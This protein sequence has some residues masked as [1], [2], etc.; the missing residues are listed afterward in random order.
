MLPEGRIGSDVCYFTSTFVDASISV[1]W[2]NLKWNSIQFAIIF[3]FGDFC[4]LI[5]YNVNMKSS[6]QHGVFRSLCKC[7][8]CGCEGHSSDLK[9]VTSYPGTFTSILFDVFHVSEVDFLSNLNS[10]LKF[11]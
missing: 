4:A 6:W 11:L 9:L 7:N 3:I 5:F 2:G 8:S 1:K 10:F